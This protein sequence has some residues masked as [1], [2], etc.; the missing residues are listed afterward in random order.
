MIFLSTKLTSWNIEQCLC[1]HCCGL[2]FI[3]NVSFRSDRQAVEACSLLQT[4][5]YTRRSEIDS[6]Q[7]VTNSHTEEINSLSI[8]VCIN[9]E[10]EKYDG[11]IGR[12]LQYHTDT[13]VWG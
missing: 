7:T 12:K 5:P 2:Y 3:L 1:L 4:H 11:Y 6:A 10:A 8:I 9:K 13:P